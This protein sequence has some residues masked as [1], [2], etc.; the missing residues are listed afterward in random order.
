MKKWKNFSSYRH[1]KIIFQGKYL[2]AVQYEIPTERP[3]LVDRSI[4]H[5]SD[6][7][8]DENRVIKSDM[9]TFFAGFTP[10]WLVYGGDLVSYTC[11]LEQAMDFMS[12]MKAGI[13]K[14]A[15]LGNWEKRRIDWLPHKFWYDSYEEIGFNLLVNAGIL[16]ERTMFKCNFIND[17]YGFFGALKQLTEPKDIILCG[18]KAE[19]HFK[20]AFSVW[21]PCSRWH[22]VPVN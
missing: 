11:R 15:V 21:F 13:A 18:C 16:S 8:W 7:H 20:L 22:L 14:F 17:L 1:R 3:E 9:N 4:A 2:V 12:A 6:L 5:F 19:D 10:D